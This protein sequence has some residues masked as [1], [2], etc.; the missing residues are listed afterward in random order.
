M[1]SEQGYQR[2]ARN[3]ER[4][5]LAG[6]CTGIGRYTGI[7]PVVFRVGFAVLVLAHG[8]G[9]FLYVAAAVLMPARPGESALAERL[10]KRWFDAPAV[11]TILG[12][13]LTAGVVFSLFGAAVT[14]TVALLVVFGLALLVAHSRGTDLVAVA[15]SVPERLT[16]HPPAPMPEP[17]RAEAETATGLREGMIDLAAYSAAHTG[18]PPL[19]DHDTRDTGAR[20]TR[21]AKGAPRPERGGS[22]V[23]AITLLGAMAA[24]AAMIPVA[25]GYPAPD[26]WLIIMAPALAVVGF[27]LVLGGWFRTRGLVAAGT[28]L[29]LAMLT[30]SV[31]RDAPQG[32]E[33]GEIEWRPTDAAQT[34]QVYKVGVGQGDLDLTSLT[35]AP[36]QR[37][38]IVAEVALGGLDVTV[39]S[40][41]RV[42]VDARV[43]LGDLR[44][45]HRTTGGP[46]AK[47]VRTLEPEG[48]QTGGEPPVIELRI[49]GKLSDVS[50]NRG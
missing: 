13:L 33:Y 50:V 35:L 36:G 46:R 45:D 10:L 29:T 38:T 7:D 34:N 6:V 28:V 2:L 15:R 27:G 21:S 14:D 25:R 49:R 4:R 37:V 30:T 11:L 1:G 44:V 39:P 19:D 41:A 32:A 48:G 20:E 5:V 9:V 43:T 22:P 18:A 8:Q 31:V 23:A 24:G 17:A 40:T 26:A 47:V 42:L 12:A 3:A 16:G